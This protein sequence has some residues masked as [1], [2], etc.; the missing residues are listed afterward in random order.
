[1]LKRKWMYGFPKDMK[2]IESSLERTKTA[3]SFTSTRSLV[4]VRN[5]VQ[6]RTTI[7]NC[8]RLEH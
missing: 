6:S 3:I 2:H 1:M 5:T 7:E 8:E 4:M